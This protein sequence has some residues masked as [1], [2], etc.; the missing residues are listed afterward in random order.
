LPPDLTLIAARGPFD[1]A[2]ETALMRDE[3]IDVV[4]SKNAGGEATY[5]KIT[6]ARALG[7]PVIM[8]ARPD[9]PAGEVVHSTDEALQWLAHVLRSRRGV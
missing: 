2:A 4:V 3:R 8:I 7:L 6:A 9:K 1:V 5:A